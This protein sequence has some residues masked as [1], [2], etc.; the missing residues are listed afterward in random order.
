[1]PGDWLSHIVSIPYYTYPTVVMGANT[2]EATQVAWLGFEN[3]ITNAR[4]KYQILY[5][6]SLGEQV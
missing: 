6:V 1:V 3:Q 4:L 2:G 5:E